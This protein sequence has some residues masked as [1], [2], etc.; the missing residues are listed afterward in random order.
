MSA[1]TAPLL[2]ISNAARVINNGGVV[3]YPTES[4]YGL[5]CDPSSTTAIQRLLELK[6]RDPHKGLIVIAASQ[7][8]LSSWLA[9][10]TS[11]WQ[12]RLD[13]DWPGAVTFVV[14]A[15]DGISPLITGGR[16]TIAVRVSANPLVQALCTA[17]DHALISTSANIS[18]ELALTS[19][20]ALHNRF[21]Q[22]LDGIVEGELGDL[23]KAT[24]IY[25]V[26]SGEQLR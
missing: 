10:L 14:P 18:G 6:A 7:Q 19:A 16:D 23:D 13:K 3:A 5:G 8:Q 25:D 12:Q 20:E 17:C 9:P 15:A 11:Q 24:P 1:N 21:G 4:V 22:T 26:R 2:S